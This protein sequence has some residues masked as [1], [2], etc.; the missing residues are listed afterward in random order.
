MRSSHPR[1]LCVEV[2]VYVGVRGREGEEGEQED[3]WRLGPAQ[4]KIE[5][6]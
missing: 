6:K 4:A 1:V 2:H 5:V 3:G